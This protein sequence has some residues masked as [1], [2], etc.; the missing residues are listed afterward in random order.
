MPK[1]SKKDK[2]KGISEAK[3]GPKDNV[4]KKE[5]V[6]EAKKESI[7]EAKK[8]PKGRDKQSKKREP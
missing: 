3:K 1:E 5:G 4:I 7:S 2:V 8:G 6:S